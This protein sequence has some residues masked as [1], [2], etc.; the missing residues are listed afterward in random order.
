MRRDVLCVHQRSG[1]QSENASH[2]IQTPLAI[3]KS[4]I[5][6][7]IQSENLT[8]EHMKQLQDIYS[9]TGRLSKLNQF[10]LLITKIENLQF[11]STKTIDLTQLIDKYVSDLDE[12]IEQKQIKV[13]KH[14]NISRELMLNNTLAE[15]LISNL[16]SNAIKH[17]VKN[18]IIK[19]TLDSKFSYGIFIIHE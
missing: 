18:G 11:N 3:I 8:K 10:L 15:I 13:E 9:A 12:L 19:I 2:E 14:Y 16:L 7:L 6:L 4:K 17:N 5:E 1:F